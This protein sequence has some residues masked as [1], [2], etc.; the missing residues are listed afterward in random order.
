MFEGADC[1]GQP[2]V[3]QDL[4]QLPIVVAFL[5]AAHLKMLENLA[6]YLG[7]DE[8]VEIGVAHPYDGFL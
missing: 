2:G 1:T 6:C 4:S 3:T 8:A 7:D 5:R